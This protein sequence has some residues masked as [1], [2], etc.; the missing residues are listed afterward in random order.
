MAK[1]GRA[2]QP[3][4]KIGAR[5]GGQ[6]RE[7]QSR[8]RAAEEIKHAAR[9]CAARRR[10]AQPPS[11]RAPQ[12]GGAHAEAADQCWRERAL[13]MPQRNAQQRKA[14]AR[15]ALQL[16]CSSPT[17]AGSTTPS[18][19]K[20]GAV[21]RKKSSAHAGPRSAR[22]EARIIAV[23]ASRLRFMSAGKSPSTLRIA[24]RALL[25]IAAGDGVGQGAMLVKAPPC[26]HRRT[27]RAW[28]RARSARSG[29]A[30]SSPSWPGCGC[31]WP[32]RP[33]HGRPR[34]S[35]PAPRCVIGAHRL[36]AIVQRGADG[37]DLLVAGMLARPGRRIRP[38]SGRGPR[39]PRAR[40]SDPAAPPMVPTRARRTTRPSSAS[41][42]RAS[43]MPASPPP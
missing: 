36:F 6:Q 39:R 30:A 42:V 15:A 35:P 43:R 28:H 11:P 13:V 21:M 1:D 34:P 40:P 23:T 33:R 29:D 14:E 5:H 16:Q 2:K 10:N 27:A 26:R 17:M 18:E 31:G 20:V 9:G 25:D 7:A 32:R 8:Q 41:R 37:G 38:R 4:Q 12:Q 24:A 19:P 22:R 3:R